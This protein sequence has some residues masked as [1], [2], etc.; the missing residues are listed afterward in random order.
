MCSTAPQG[1]LGARAIS[2]SIF[3]GTVRSPSLLCLGCNFFSSRITAAC[4]LGTH[5]KPTVP[6]FL[7]RGGTHIIPNKSLPTP[8]DLRAPPFSC[9]AGS[10]DDDPPVRDVH[11]LRVQRV[12]GQPPWRRP[13]PLLLVPGRLTRGGK[14]LGPGILILGTVVYSWPILSPAAAR[15]ATHRNP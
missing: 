6:L 13:Q 9:C 4:C 7:G 1:F 3:L 8:A 12:D 15:G 14:G 10:G 5:P 11:D 2:N